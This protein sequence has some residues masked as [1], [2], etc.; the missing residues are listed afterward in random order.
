MFTLSQHLSSS[1]QLQ[2]THRINLVSFGVSEENCE[3][4]IMSIQRRGNN[5]RS[6]VADFISPDNGLRGA[7]QRKGAQPKNHMRDNVRNIRDTEFK[8]REIKELEAMEPQKELY[9]LR[10]FRDVESRLHEPTTA[11]DAASRQDAGDG[12]FLAKGKAEQMRADIAEANRNKRA[13][14][15]ADLEE[16]KLNAGDDAPRRRASVPRAEETLPIAPRTNKNFIG[17]NKVKAQVMMPPKADDHSDKGAKHEAFGRLPDYLLDRKMKAALEE[18]ERKRN[19]PDPDCP[20]GMKRMPEEERLSTLEVLNSSREECLK[21]LS[22]LPF[23]VETPMMKRKQE[24]L[25]L[26]L[27]EIENALELFRKPKAGC[28]F[29][30]LLR[31]YIVVNINHVA[32]IP[33]FYLL[34]VLLRSADSVSKYFAVQQFVSIVTKN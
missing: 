6:A 21:Q 8:N 32:F 9:K 31:Q 34:Q 33:T 13:Q 27:K 29:T 3:G 17:E 24:S 25:E 4:T 20:P 22:K 28:V 10:Q 14:L 11:F 30:S 2:H 16:A 18:E 5:G 12:V 15:K 26:K 1:P 19:A 23:V 7:M